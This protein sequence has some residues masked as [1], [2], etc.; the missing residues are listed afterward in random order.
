MNVGEYGTFYYLNVNFDMS[1][2]TKLTL[3]FVRPGGT[4][5]TRHEDSVSVPI[6]DYVSVFG[7]TLPANQ[8]IKYKWRDGDLAIEGEY[9]V[10]LTYYNGDKQLVS[11]AASFRVNP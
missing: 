9:I 8:Y 10:R 6:A 4:K 1:D 2:Y 3:E 7:G 11:D 5:F